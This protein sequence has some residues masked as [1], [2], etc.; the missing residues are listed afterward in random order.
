M[1]TLLADFWSAV[2]SSG[3]CATETTASGFS[4][5]L[6]LLFRSPRGYLQGDPGA[7]PLG[8]PVERRGRRR[9]HA[10]QLRRLPGGQDEPPRPHP[11][12]IGS[13]GGGRGA[14]RSASPGGASRAVCGGGTGHGGST[15]A[16]VTWD[17]RVHA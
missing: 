2:P 15:R 5:A 9:P 8:E 7:G 10:R 3:S 13:G 17:V 4:A 12:A 6:L 1:F 16:S 14:L 11:P